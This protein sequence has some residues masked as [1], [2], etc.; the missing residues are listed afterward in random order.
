LPCT[1]QEVRAWRP[2]D[3]WRLRRKHVIGCRISRTGL[4]FMRNGSEYRIGQLHVPA[5]GER[6]Q[7]CPLDWRL[8]GPQSQF[9]RVRQEWN[10]GFCRQSNRILPVVKPVG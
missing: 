7:M 4:S 9:G 6:S 1:G 10:L 3:N 2:S 8:G 5:A